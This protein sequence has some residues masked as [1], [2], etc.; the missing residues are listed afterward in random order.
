MTRRSAATTCGSAR[1]HICR[2]GGQLSPFANVSRNRNEILDPTDSK[3]RLPELFRSY[4]FSAGTDLDITKRIGVGASY[5]LVDTRE[6]DQH[7]REHYLNLGTSFFVEDSVAVGVRGSIFAQ[8]ISGESMT[9]GA[10]SV[11]VTARLLL[12]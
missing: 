6:P 12:N 9:T 7:V 4:T 10:R 11:F 2:R 3:Y 8:Q 5:A 1:A